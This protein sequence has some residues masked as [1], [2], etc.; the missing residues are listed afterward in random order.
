MLGLDLGAAAGAVVPAG[1]L[2]AAV[3]GVLV[4]DV[5]VLDIPLLPSCLV[6]LLVGLLKPLRPALAAGVG[7]DVPITALPRLPD[8]TSCFFRPLSPTCKLTG[9]VFG[10]PVIPGAFAGFCVVCGAGS[11]C[12]SGCSSTCRT[13]P[14]RK[15]MP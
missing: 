8:T 12:P 7:L 2:V 10:A 4:L 3:G 5:D 6:G 13:P 1:L 9:R 15:N 11:G 14:G